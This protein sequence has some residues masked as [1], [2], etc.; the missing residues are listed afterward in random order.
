L[1]PDFAYFW[2]IEADTEASMPPTAPR[3]QLTY[4][5]L[6]G[7][8]V[9]FAG[10]LVAAETLRLRA[11]MWMPYNGDPESKN[12]GYVVELAKAIFEPQG[13]KVDYQTMPWV[14]A[15]ESARTGKTDGV[16]GAGPAELEGLKAPAEPIGE[17][18]YVMLVRKDNPWKYEKMA[19]LKGLKLGVIEGY[20]Y[21]EALDK[22]IQANKAPAIVVFKGDAPLA[23]GLNQ[24]KAGE[25]DVMPEN[26]TVFVWTVRSIGMS[27]SDFRIAYTWQSEPIYLAFSKNEKGE[28]Y[29]KLFDEGMRKMRASGE[30][31]KLLKHYDLTEW[32]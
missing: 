24:L 10:S 1:L 16:I 15:L 12:P 28:H 25:I 8:F 2:G 4:I 21:W 17:P 3:K 11:D 32:K 31:A 14:E 30:L 23:D 29:A 7:L 22:Y 9:A 13:I 19:S 20:S 18:R 5:H 6:F 27:P 26:M